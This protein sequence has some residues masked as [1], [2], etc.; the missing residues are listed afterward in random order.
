MRTASKPRPTTRLPRDGE[1]M[2][3]RPGFRCDWTDC[4][5]PAVALRY[6]AIGAAWIPV[7]ERH[8]GDEDADA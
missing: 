4:H 3:V 8:R 7:C 6:D 5:R 2:E 1:L